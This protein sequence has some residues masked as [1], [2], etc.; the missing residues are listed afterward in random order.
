MIYVTFRQE[1]A[2]LRKVHESETTSQEAKE[3]DQIRLA[4][5]QYFFQFVKSFVMPGCTVI[6]TFAVQK[7][8]RFF[9]TQIS[10][11]VALNS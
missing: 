9:F 7:N 5:Q 11:T 8:Q 3:R 2:Q 1:R 4:L 10:C 6:L